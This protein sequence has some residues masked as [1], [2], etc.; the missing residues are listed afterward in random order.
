MRFKEAVFYW[1]LGK[2]GWGLLEKHI[3]YLVS[4]CSTCAPLRLKSRKFSPTL[5]STAL[6]SSPRQWVI[7]EHP[8]KPYA[9]KFKQLQQRFLLKSWKDLVQILYVKFTLLLKNSQPLYSTLLLKLLPSNSSAFYIPCLFLWDFLVSSWSRLMNRT[10]LYFLLI[11][12]GYTQN[13]LPDPGI[14]Y[15]FLFGCL[16]FPA[17]RI[18]FWYWKA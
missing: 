6:S 16:R 5:W 4:P 9:S 18:C 14:L 8:G 12:Q 17:L 11:T 1:S 2:R 15:F 13:S 7:Y 3:C 10:C